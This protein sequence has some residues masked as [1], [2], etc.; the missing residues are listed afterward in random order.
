VNT[1]KPIM[2]DAFDFGLS[3]GVTKLMEVAKLPSISTAVPV[4]FSLIF[5][6]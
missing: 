1:I 4:S 2:L 6:R 5:K 3:E